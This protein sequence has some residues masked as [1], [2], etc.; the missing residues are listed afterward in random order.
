[1][2]RQF[3]AR[4]PEVPA[5][6]EK[7]TALAREFDIPLASHDDDTP[8]ARAA[9]RA[10]GCTMCEFP[11][12]HATAN[13]ARQAGEDI[14][15]GSPNILRGGSHCGRVGA[16]EM[17]RQGLCSILCSDY[18]YPA[19]LVAPFIL[20][21]NKVAPFAAAWDLVSS[22]PARAAKLHDRGTLSEGKRADLLIIDDTDPLHPEVRAAFVEGAPVYT[23]G[24]NFTGTRQEVVQ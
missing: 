8:E 9:Y 4:D 13:A 10:L 6:L 1:M 16:G 3:L 7:L 5:S 23:R 19:V 18:Y 15:L 17:I 14:I 11:A 22:A 24:M 12:D 2:A 20:A 21:V